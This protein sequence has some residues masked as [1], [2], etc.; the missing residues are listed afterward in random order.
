[1]TQTLADLAREIG[2]SRE[3]VRQLLPEYARDRAH[4]ALCERLKRYV[5]AHPS[6]VLTPA[7][8]GMTYIAIAADLGVDTRSLRLAWRVCGLPA[9]ALQK[10]TKAEISRLGYAKRR[11]EHYEL[12]KAW[13][14]RNPER[15]REIHLSAN[16]RHRSKKRQARSRLSANGGS[17][18]VDPQT[19]AKFNTLST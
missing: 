12:V 1:M 3:R 11:R 2:V 8:G 16:A 19:V 9:R 10:L 13:K 4:R 14:A 15:A 6:S 17:S 7:R 18:G 5:E